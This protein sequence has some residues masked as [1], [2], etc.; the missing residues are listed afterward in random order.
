MGK[1]DWYMKWLKEELDKHQ[2]DWLTW[3]GVRKYQKLAEEIGENDRQ[4]IGGRSRLCRQMME[5]YGITQIE[6]INILNGFHA[7]DYVNKYHRIKNQIPLNVKKE[8]ANYIDEDEDG[9]V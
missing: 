5:E 7:G 6:A 8:T 4:I 1:R 2:G 3:E 9:D